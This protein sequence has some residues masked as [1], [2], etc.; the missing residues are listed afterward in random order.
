MPK[1]TDLSA[2]NLQVSGVAEVA[3]GMEPAAK[4]AITAVATSVT[5]NGCSPKGVYEKA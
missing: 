4:V 3:T 5:E 1:A 2:T